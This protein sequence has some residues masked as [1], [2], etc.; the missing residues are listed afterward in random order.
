MSVRRPVVRAVIADD[1]PL[2]RQ[3]LRDL[4]AAVPWIAVAGEAGRSTPSAL[5]CCS[6]TSRCPRAMDSKSS[7]NSITD[8]T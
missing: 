2:A 1:E 8:H 3:Q 6:W 7:T 4:L 5:I